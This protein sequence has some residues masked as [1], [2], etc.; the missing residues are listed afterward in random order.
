MVRM[1]HQKHVHTSH[2]PPSSWTGCR[3]AT[4]KGSTDSYVPCQPK[5]EKLLFYIWNKGCFSLPKSDESTSHLISPVKSNQKLFVDSSTCILHGFYWVL[6]DDKPHD[7]VDTI[8][9]HRLVFYL[10]LLHSLFQ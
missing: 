10:I 1:C 3:L 2:G 7:E 5:L 8:N 4:T 6:Q 9:C